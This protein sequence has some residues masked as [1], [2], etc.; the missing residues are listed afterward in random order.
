MKRVQYHYRQHY[1]MWD[2]IGSQ[3]LQHKTEAKV[4]KEHRNKPRFNCFLCEIHST[5]CGQ[6]PLDK[7]SNCYQINSIYKNWRRLSAFPDSI[8]F[9]EQRPY[10]YAIRDCVIPYLTPFS[11]RVL[12]IVE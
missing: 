4:L 5:S 7:I 3:D 10:A 9:R 12:R 11:K 8:F 2:E 6:C 1:R